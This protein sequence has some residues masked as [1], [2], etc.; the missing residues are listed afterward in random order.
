MVNKRMERPAKLHLITQ[1]GLVQLA[2]QLGY[3]VDDDDDDVVPAVAALLTALMHELVGTLLARADAKEPGARSFL[4]LSLS[5]NH[6]YTNVYALVTRGST[7]HHFCTI[8]TAAD[9]G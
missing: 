9:H 8:H 5:L 2:V 4:P 1:L 6:S 7:A 3:A